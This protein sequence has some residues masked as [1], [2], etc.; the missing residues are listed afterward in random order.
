MLNLVWTFFFLS[1]FG[2]ALCKLLFLGDAQ[3]FADIMTAMFELAKTAFEISLGL[4]G[5]LALW[6]GIMK[7]GEHS[8]FTGL[9]TQALNPLFNRL[10]PEIPQNHPALGAMTMNMAANM[11]GLDNAATPMGIKAMQA[12]QTLNPHPEQASDA[13]IL[14][15]VLNTSSVTLFPVTIFAYRA[16]LGAV[17]PTDVFIPILIATYVSTLTGLLAVAAVQRINLLDKVVLAYLGGISA[18]VI[19]ILA[20]FAGLERAA[21]LKQSAQVSHI[22]LFGLVIAFIAAAVYKRLNAYELFIEGAKEGFQTAITII[23]YL[24]AMLVAFGVFRAS[25]GL[26]LLTDAMRVAVGALGIDNRFI[27]GLPTALMKPFSGSGARAMMIDTLKTHGA[28]SFAGR[29]VSVIQG[30]T[31][32]TFYVL[33]VYFGAVNIKHIRHA[34]ACGLIADFGGITAAILLTYWFFG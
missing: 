14:F 17:N 1:A 8:G 22:V 27:D 12:M 21:M 34:A 15:L 3:V 13:Q 32:T 2:I 5:V 25:G 29:L 31:E 6:L 19:G 18:I 10:M 26:L 24:V 30:S 33:A 20:Y 9:L 16:Q 28:D 4:S 7:I 23:P 11:L